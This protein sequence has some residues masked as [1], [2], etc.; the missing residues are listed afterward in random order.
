MVGPQPRLCSALREVSYLRA[1]LSQL[2]SPGV[3]GNFLLLVLSAT[4][5]TF[6]LF[7]RYSFLVTSSLNKG[8]MRVQFWS[9]DVFLYKSLPLMSPL[10]VVISVVGDWCDVFRFRCASEVL[11]EPTKPWRTVTNSAF[12][13]LQPVVFA[14][15]TRVRCMA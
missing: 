14:R 4:G 7:S 3:V 13:C 5:V 9:S 2:L 10:W 8:L 12:A 6:S 11:L 15:C 1:F